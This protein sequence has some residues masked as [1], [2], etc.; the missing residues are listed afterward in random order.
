MSHDEQVF[1]RINKL[2][3]QKHFTQKD[4]ISYLGLTRG[5]YTNW[6]RGKSTTYLSYIEEISTFFGV[7]ANYLITGNPDMKSDVQLYPLTCEELKMLETFRKYSESDR[8]FIIELMA[9]L[10]NKRQFEAT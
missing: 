6:S 3:T 4:L 2:L 5:T 7:N 9:L 10:L 1:D 8:S